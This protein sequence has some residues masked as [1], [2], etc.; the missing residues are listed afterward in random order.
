LKLAGVMHDAI[1]PNCIGNA[2][3]LCIKTTWSAW[4]D[5]GWYSPTRS[6]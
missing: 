3:G 4:A 6:R 2:V 5:G 1:F